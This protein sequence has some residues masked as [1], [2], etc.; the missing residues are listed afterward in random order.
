M[1]MAETSISAAMGMPGR[2]LSRA[3]GVAAWASTSM[4]TRLAGPQ[5][6]PTPIWGRGPHHWARRAMSRVAA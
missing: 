3:G 1:V 5:E 6:T 4:T 2:S